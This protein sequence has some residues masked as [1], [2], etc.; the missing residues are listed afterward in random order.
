MAIAADRMAAPSMTYEDYMAEEE[1]MQ[2]YDIID[3]VR[4][5]MNPTRRHQRIL[6]NLLKILDAF[7]ETFQIGAALLSPCDI[8]IRR[9]PLRTRQP[10]I[11][12]I[13]A[14][15]LAKN[16]EETVPSPLDHAPELV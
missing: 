16:A 10:D 1:T 6:R 3:G 4:I 8:L 15:Q 12:F 14:E 11:S 5:V 7:E 13:S 2:R 9:A